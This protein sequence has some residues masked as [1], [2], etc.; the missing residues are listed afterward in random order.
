MTC[1]NDESNDKSQCQTNNQVPQAIIRP[2]PHATSLD[3][4]T[5]K[6]KNIEKDST[7]VLPNKNSNL[8][9]LKQKAK[10]QNEF[11]R[12]FNHSPS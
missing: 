8:S 1:E 4:I 10:K 2:V 6:H 12:F 9:E 11:C 3:T 5:K 7:P